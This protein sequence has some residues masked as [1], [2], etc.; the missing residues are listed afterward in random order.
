GRLPEVVRVERRNQVAIGR[1]DS[2]VSSGRHAAVR[3]GNKA[4]SRITLDPRFD[5]GPCAVSR[6]VVNDDDL[7]MAVGLP[8]RRCQRVSDKGCPVAHGQDDRYERRLVSHSTYF[9][10]QRRQTPSPLM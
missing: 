2:A 10:R 1:R 5:N 3:L 7:E 8:K 6:S 4:Y 9:S